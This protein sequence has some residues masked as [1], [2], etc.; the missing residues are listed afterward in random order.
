MKAIAWC[1]MIGLPNVLPVIKV[2]G[3]LSQ[4]RCE[5]LLTLVGEFGCFRQGALSNSDS[6][7]GNERTSD[8]E[9]F[10][11]NLEAVALLY[12]ESAYAKET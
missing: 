9:R 11:R 7:G 1:S 6:S 3:A 12:V 8:V 2:S 10:H 4:T 5:M